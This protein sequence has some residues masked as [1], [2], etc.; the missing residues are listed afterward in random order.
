VVPPVLDV[1]PVPSVPVEVV[2]SVVGVV[3]PGS[4]VEVAPLVPPVGLSPSPGALPPLTD[5]ASVADE[6]VCAAPFALITL[7]GDCCGADAAGLDGVTGWALVESALT[8]TDAGVT[9]GVVAAALGVE[10][11]SA[12]RAWWRAW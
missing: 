10:S 1:V 4:V 9:A 11:I 2:G 6:L 7:V 12:A 5:T 3:A 8:L